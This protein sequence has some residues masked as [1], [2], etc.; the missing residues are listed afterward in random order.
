VRRP[1]GTEQ[2]GGILILFWLSLALGVIGHLR[3]NDADAS[4]R[5]KRKNKMV[6]EAL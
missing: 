4:R 3:Q 1:L 2:F 5:E 6:E